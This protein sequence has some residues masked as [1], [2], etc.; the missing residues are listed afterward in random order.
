M[1]LDIWLYTK[2]DFGGPKGP[3]TIT[4]YDANITHNLGRMWGAAGVYD[5]LYESEGK[6]AA[7]ILPALEVGVDAMLERPDDFRKYDAPNGWGLYEHA[8]P[9][10][11]RL[12]EAC[13]D[14]PKATIGISR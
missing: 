5:A 11:Q 6:T 3:E 8:L 13:R 12:V 2:V 10:L 9:W 1:S 4:H 14:Y 7:D